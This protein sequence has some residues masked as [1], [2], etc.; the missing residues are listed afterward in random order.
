M[1]LTEPQIARYARQILL[2]AVGGEGQQALLA[3]VVR[4]VGEGLAASTAASYLQAGGTTVMSTAFSSGFPVNPNSGS[5][6][7][8]TVAVA[9]F[10][11]WP[12]GARVLVGEEGVLVMPAGG[13]A[14][15]F[16]SKTASWHAPV[17]QVS[18]GAMAALAWQRL[19]LGLS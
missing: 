13:D 10:C 8:G 12:M 11:E 3:S 2:Q 19:V 14:A 5:V 9:P 7:H 18:A 15:R 4:V 1:S 6:A 17:D 16:D